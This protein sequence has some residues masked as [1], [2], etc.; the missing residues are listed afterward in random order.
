[1]ANS[2]R[3]TDR[4]RFSARLLRLYL[5]Y[6]F[7]LSLL[8]LGVSASTFAIS[9]VG[10]F[11][12]R[13]YL[14]T[15][16][17]YVVLCAITLGFYQLQNHRLK[18]SQLLLTLI[19]DIAIQTLLMYCS[20]GLSSGIGYLMIVTVAAG[21]IFF[22]GQMAILIPAIGSICIIL[23]GVVA[24]YVQGRDDASIVPAGVLGILLFL[25]ALLFLRLSRALTAAQREAQQE[26]E[27][28][29]ELQ[30]LNQ[31]VVNRMH[32]GILVVDGE[33]RILQINQAAR[34]LLGHAPERRALEIGDFILGEPRLV[35]RLQNWKQRPS[36]KARPFISRFGNT[37]LQASFAHLEQSGRESTII[38]LEDFR[39]AAQQAQQLKFA[40]L[41]RLTASIAHEI[42]NPLGAISHASELLEEI[43]DDDTVT[44][45]LTQIIATQVKRVNRIV[46]SVLQLSRQG[47]YHPQRLAI[48]PWLQ[49]FI[50]Q[51]RQGRNSPADIQLDILAAAPEVTFDP[52]HLQ[53]VLTN[54]L[55]NALRH[56]LAAT[57]QASACIQVDRLAM[58]NLVNLDIIDRGPGVPVADRNKLFEPFFSTSSGGSGLG[59]FIARELCTINYATIKYQPPENG[60][61]SFFRITFIHPEK[62]LNATSAAL[63][64][65]QSP[66]HR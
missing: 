12:P 18:S 7:F 11:A 56:S 30:A 10:S 45:R 64:N 14:S 16:I 5:F 9:L 21:A 52:V 48:A 26:S 63:E 54:L 1:M 46:E 59:L 23:E 25:T 61:S 29:A 28:S 66:D 58:E 13:L 4:E 53:Q 2:G 39:A 43:R 60:G 17:V 57:G 55:D 15:A 6:R 3:N 49:E 50:A 37:E 19:T 32:T 38:F 34:R 36:V 65:G 41:G 22:S 27:L 47:K 33:Q 8:L 20:G 40:S 24:I 44:T 51:Y 42:R 35:T 31:L 62:V